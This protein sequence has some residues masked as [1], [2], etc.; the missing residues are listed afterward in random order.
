M[1]KVNLSDVL[2][3]VRVEVFHTIDDNSLEIVCIDKI[4]TYGEDS[5][6]W[7]NYNSEVEWLTKHAEPAWQSQAFAEIGRHIG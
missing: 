5:P 3:P 4:E 1:M 7:G 6:E 2:F